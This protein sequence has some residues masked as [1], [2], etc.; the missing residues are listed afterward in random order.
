[1]SD[2]Q[3]G[4]PQL[5]DVQAPAL[6]RDMPYWCLWRYETHAGDKKPRKVPLYAS[7]ERR[8]GQQGAPADLAKLT[9]FAVA[10]DAAI[11]RGMDGVG[12]AH[13]EAGGI[14]ILDFDNCVHDGVVDPQVLD[15]VKNTYAEF[16]P[17][18]KGV[19]AIFSASHDVLGNPK[20]HA[21]G[22]QFGV[23]VFS[24]KGFVTCTGNILPHVDILGY[25]DRV[26][27]LSQ[28]VIDFC[29]ARFGTSA[30]AKVDP[31]DFMVGREPRLGLTVERMEEL[32][33]SLDPDM[34]REDWIK[35]GMAL[36]HECGGDDTGFEIFNEW[37]ACGGKYPSEE[38]LRQQWDS[39]G[40][41]RATGRRQITMASVIKMVKDAQKLLQAEDLRAF[42]KGV[43]DAP[44]GHPGVMPAECYTGKF[45][46]YHASHPDLHKPMEWFIKGVLPVSD[47]IVL[48]GASGSGKSFVAFDMAA[49]IARGIAWQGCRVKRA[50]VVFVVA[51]GAGGMKNRINAYCQHHG[52]EPADLDIS[53]VLAAPNVLDDDDVSE[54]AKSIKS[55]GAGIFVVD[56]FAQVTPGADENSGKDMG[57]ALRNL[58]T[59]TE[60]TGATA[61]VVHHTG[62]D[63]ARGARG[64]SGIRAAADAEIEISASGNVRLISLKKLKEG[65]DSRQWSFRL[66]IVGLGTDSDG[67]PMSSCVVEYT[68]MSPA[69]SAA[70]RQPKG[71]IQ[72]RVLETA[73]ACG[74]STPQGALS[75]AIIDAAVNSIPYD[76]IQAEGSKK[77]RDQRRTHAERSLRGL[78]EG[79]F[80]VA[81]GERIFLPGFQHFA[82]DANVCDHGDAS[83][84]SCLK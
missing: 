52:L 41:P 19:H 28:P 51:E 54:L 71:A 36:H 63:A 3:V 72:K 46:I 43:A 34:C 53:F 40:R 57:R 81:V 4:K 14:V 9:T 10:R 66:A 84:S 30:P 64:W 32:V 5:R 29:R 78:C 17:S 23:E 2:M 50:K 35:C 67:D 39:F 38:A 33:S 83:A 11:R 24:S 79:E 62:K 1:M 27:P 25:E 8:Y 13:T 20:S 58:R 77:P 59:I 75:T 70:P 73:R 82:F 12:F 68:D 49:V 26:A 61:L 48:Y 47:L 56:T 76:P 22:D 18:G 21:D 55:S 44:E 31:E 45:R 42:Y 65:D 37:S 16:S 15:L 74:A 7:G 80:L 69:M 60:A 6:L